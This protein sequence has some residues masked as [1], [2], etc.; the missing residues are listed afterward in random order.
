MKGFTSD[1]IADLLTRIRN[2]QM[3]GHAQVVLPGSKIKL[4]ICEILQEF[5]YIESVR[6]VDEGPQGKVAVT[7]RYDDENAPMIRRLRRVSKPSRRIYVGADD[8]PQ[9][10]NGLGLAI[11]S[12]SR[13][14][15]SDRDA[16]A[17]K[18]GGEV[19]CT[20]Y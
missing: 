6:W 17:A 3:A 19:L 5:G 15:L 2:A 1:P 18:V 16:R 11:L 8:I 7:L 9:V 12:T 20:V 14:V 10:L 4:A 13:G